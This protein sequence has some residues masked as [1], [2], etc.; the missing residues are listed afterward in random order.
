MS[1]IPTLKKLFSLISV[2]MI[3]AATDCA[4][5]A[6]NVANGWLNW[7]GPHQ[8]GTSDETNL[9]DTWAVGGENNLWVRD[10]PGQ[11][12]PVIAN[13]RLYVMGMKGENDANMQEGLF[14][15]D[16]AT[17]KIIWDRCYNDFTSDTIYLRYA[18]SAPV[19]DP[20]TGNIFSLGSQGF[21]SSYDSEGKLLWQHTMM[22][23]LGFMTFPNGRTG[24]PVIEGPLVIVSCTTANWGANGPAAN[25][26]YAFDKKTGDLV[27]ASNTES[28]PKENSLSTPIIEWVGNKR[29]MY[30]AGGDGNLYGINSHTGE[31]VWIY[32][33]CKSGMTS[34]VVTYKGMIIAVHGRENLD[35][36]GIGRMVCLKIPEDTAAVDGKPKVLDKSVEV[37]R[38]DV[39]SFGSSPILVGERIYISDDPARLCCVDANTGKMIWR[40]ALSVE[41]VFSSIAYADGKLFVP[42]LD[43]T[44]FII[45][46]GDTEES[47]KILS[48]VRLDAKC[49]GAPAICDGRVYI[50]SGLQMDGKLYC[51]GKKDANQKAPAWPAAEKRAPG[52]LAKF[53]GVPAD[54][55]VHPGKTLSLRL[56]GVDKDGQFLP[57]NPDDAK[58]AKWERYIPPTAKVKAMISGDV[59]DGVFKAEDKLIPSAGALKADLNGIIGTTRGRIMPSLPIHVKF[60]SAVLIP[61]E[62]D[63]T[64]K[65]AYP[66]LPWIGARFRWEIRELNGIKALY[67]TVDNKLFQRAMTFVGS[68][69][70]SDYTIQ[71]DVLSAGEKKKF[72]VKMSEVGVVCQRYIVILK[73]GSQEIEINSNFERFRVA[74]KFAWTPDTW[75][76]IKARVDIDPATGAGVVRGKAWKK[77]EPEPE[78]WTI[79]APHQTAHKIGAPGVFGFVP[80]EVPVYIDNIVVT[81]NK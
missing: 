81:P 66:P 29:M 23:E 58:K 41:V 31:T 3:V 59:T 50:Q 18:S 65:F 62:T 49:C 55:L 22:D 8:N 17:G 33:M 69:E 60:D 61:S 74:T 64:A 25:R 34:T 5:A 19:V 45:K 15:L 6:D 80:Q 40:K 54:F 32:P 36:S 4:F 2:T 73:G 39:S 38:S 26:F 28:R 21:M 76:T 51:I 57:E 16:A 72:I 12:A 63:P 67:K 78:K 10:I 44:F 42:V 35:V 11:S 47:T 53:I 46:P 30:V 20:E 48:K 7:R 75:Y 9:P 14:C 56:L 79:E 27:W 71:A 77:G 43:G 70:M 52:A 37:W 68:P 13:G 1:K 24:R